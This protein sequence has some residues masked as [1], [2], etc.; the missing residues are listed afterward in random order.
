M[1]TAINNVAA[2]IFTSTTA[3][4]GRGNWVVGIDPAIYSHPGIDPPIHPDDFFLPES[5]TDSGPLL[6]DLPQVTG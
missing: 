6:I 2:D 4:T 5:E 1:A 3:I